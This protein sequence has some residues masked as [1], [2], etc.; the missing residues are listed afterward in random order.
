MAKQTKKNWT[1]IKAQSSWRMFKIMAEF[2]DGFEKLDETGPCVSIFGSARTQPNNAYYQHAETLAQK[3]VEAGY[4]IITGG[5]PGIMEAANKG[6]KESGG[7]S[8]G[9]HIE[10]PHEE[11]C[12]QYV[13]PDKIIAFKY[14][15]A[16]KVM[17]IRYAQA[18]VY[19]PG[20]FGTMDELFEVLTLVQTKKIQHIPMIF[21]GTD[22]WKGL[23]EW[24]EKTMLHTAHNISEKDLKLFHITDDTSEVVRIIESHY[25]NKKLTPNF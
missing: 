7:V 14:F 23:L 3:L 2:V 8:V 24:I 5:G 18:V 25:A 19:M 21:F 1:E 12:N 16:R 9:L 10:L 20:G 11:G 22:Y 6:A 15:F 4:G 17:F 13:D